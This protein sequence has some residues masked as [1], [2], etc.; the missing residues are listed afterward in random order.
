MKKQ[1]KPALGTNQAIQTAGTGNSNNRTIPSDVAAPA[2]NDVTKP[3]LYTE[4][5]SLHT[6]LLY[7]SH[8]CTQSPMVPILG[9]QV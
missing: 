4:H 9:K 5:R 1:N 7:T 2:K 3:L 8:C 6:Q